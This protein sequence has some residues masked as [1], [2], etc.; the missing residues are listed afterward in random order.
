MIRQALTQQI[1][2][3]AGEYTVEG[4][5]GGNTIRQRDHFF[6]KPLAGI[7]R[8]NHVFIIFTMTQTS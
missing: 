8:Q 5:M 3:Q 1:R 4:V 6:Q 7:A 2:L